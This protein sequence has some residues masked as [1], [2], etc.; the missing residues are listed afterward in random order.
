MK[1]R[2]FWAAGL[3]SA[4]GIFAATQVGAFDD[5]TRKLDETLTLD[6]C[7]GVCPGGVSAANVLVERDIYVL[8]ANCETKFADW[9]AYRVSAESFGPS[10]RRTWRADPALN[11]A[12]TLE[13]EDYRGAHAALGTDRGHQAPLASFAGT[14]A[15]ADTNYLSNITPQRSALNQGPWKN[16]EAAVRVAAI[17]GERDVFVLTGPLYDGEVGVLPG[18]DEAHTVPSGYWKVIAF[19]DGDV[20]GFIFEQD[21]PRL[22]AF[23]DYAVSIA[24]IERRSGLT[25]PQTDGVLSNGVMRALGCAMGE[26]ASGA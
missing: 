26:G 8:S 17:D 5:E 18:A 20:S 9:V 23:C 25:L 24:D 6:L 12:C 11:E 21:T 14:D 3:V 22:A 19:A 2:L 1:L 13:P 10:Q 16:L 4:S 15:W 7:G